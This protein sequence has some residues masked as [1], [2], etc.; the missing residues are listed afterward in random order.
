[1]LGAL[2]GRS[3]VGAEEGAGRWSEPSSAIWARVP[4]A[5]VSCCVSATHIVGPPL[6]LFDVEGEQ[7]G[8]PSGTGL[9]FDC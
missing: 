5:S 2:S 9:V 8:L 3:S 4:G 6:T 7:Y 1:M